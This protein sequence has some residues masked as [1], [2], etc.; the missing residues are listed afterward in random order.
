MPTVTRIV[1]AY[2]MVMGVVVG[3]WAYGFPDRFYSAFPGFGLSWVS[4]D[5]PYN[6]HL[7]ED[8]GAAYL[9]MAALSA[10]G[11]ARPLSVTPFAVGLATLVFNG[12][13][14]AYH[15]THLGMFGMTDRVL[16]I[17]ALGSAVLGSAWLLTPQARMRP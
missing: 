5:G 11:L 7:V 17:L 15:A 16:N 1:L 10:L 3:V 4:M 12:L 8:A 13:H 2:L 9:M 6:R 14:F